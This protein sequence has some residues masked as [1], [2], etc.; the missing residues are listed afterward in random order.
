[1]DFYEFHM[2]DSD[3]RTKD[4]EYQ[5]ISLPKNLNLKKLSVHCVEQ[6]NDGFILDL[7]SKNE[8]ILNRSIKEIENLC[9][10][11]VFLQEQ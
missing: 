6:F 8:Q 5:K 10:N 3:I 1:M 7:A 2:S 9:S 11:A 4:F